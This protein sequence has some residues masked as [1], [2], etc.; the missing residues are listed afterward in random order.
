MK[1][2]TTNFRSVL[3]R[4]LVVAGLRLAL[5][6]LPFGSASPLFAQGNTS[7]PK[8]ILADFNH[9]GIPDLLTPSLQTTGFTISFGAV[10]YGTFSTA[11]ALAPY[12]VGC[13]GTAIPNFA[14]ADFNGDGIPD[15]ALTC[16]NGYTYSLYVMLGKGDG[17]FTSPVFLNGLQNVFVGD[18]NKDGKQDIVVEGGS[19][20]T[21]L[22]FYPGNGD[23]TF[24]N[25]TSTYISR[26]YASGVTVDINADG[27]PDLAFVSGSS[28]SVSLDLYL[29]NQNGTFG[30]IANYSASPN[31][32]ATLTSS[33]IVNA[34]SLLVGNL[35]GTGSNGLAVV[36]TG[37]VPGIFTLSYTVSGST[38]T[39]SSATKVPFAG[40]T[41]AAVGSIVSGYADLL[42][43]NG[44][45]LTVYANDGSGD[46]NPTFAN[47]TLP[48]TASYFGV[49]DANGDGYA[50]VFTANPSATGSALTVA[51]V[52]GSATAVSA[53]LTLPAGTDPLAV[54]WKGNVN[55]TGSTSTGQQI[56]NQVASTVALGS[57]PNPAL[58]GNS[59]T[60]TATVAP[61]GGV[62]IVPTGSVNFFDG[63]KLLGNVPLG[64][65]AVAT[66]STSALAVGTHTISA[67][68]SG[69]G[70][71]SASSNSLSQ[72]INQ[73]TP[74][75]SWTPP[76]A[77]TYGTAL[78]ATQLNATAAGITG[79]ALPGTFVYTP[80]A[81]TVLNAG[82]QTL[83]VTFTPTDTVNYTTAT[84]TVA[85]V[86]NPATPLIA[87][88]P[89]VASIVYG[90]ALGAQQLN[91][92]ATGVGGAP[93]SGNFVYTPAS[94][95]VP[96]AGTQRLSVVFLPGSTNY[97]SATGSASIN[98]TQAT[99]TLSWTTPAAIAYGIPLS[100]TQLNATAAGVSG[101]ALPGT[102]VY[103][104]AAG[105]ILN[106]G[107]QTLSVT[108]T[109]TD[110][111][112]YA[113]ATT[114][115]K[116]TVTDIALTS[117]TP[118]SVGLGAANTTITITGSGFVAT[119]VAQIGG[120]AIAT[121]L[122]NP[123]TLTAIVPAADFA[124]PGTL[125]LTLK[126]PATGSVSGSLPLT[127]TAP[128]VTATLT[129]PA[130][131]SPGSQPVIGL[132]IP[133]YPVAL[134]ATFTLTTTADPKVGV[135]DPNVLF[136]NGLTTY[137]FTIP[138]GST[139]IPTVQLQAGTV[140]ETITVPL[141]LTANGVNVT[142]TNLA[143]AVILVPEAVPVATA[144]TL[145]RSGSTL[146]V[147]I[148][149]F[150][151]TREIVSAAFHFVAASGSTL[152]TTDVPAPVGTVFATYYGGTASQP[153]GSSFVY[154]QVFNVSGDAKAVGSV[155]VTLTNSIGQ[156]V[157]VTAQ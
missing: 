106:P 98:V 54:A 3:A 107:T 25:F 124:L 13:S 75:L 5:V 35:Y 118:N 80:A 117:F 121:T 38:V 146:T 154:T 96:S 127:V 40:L 62:Q 37:A 16:S 79:G 89:A 8:M 9:D 11:S 111:V 50:D 95:T 42:V 26:N 130:S 71:F 103:T 19:D 64:T 86:V 136:S 36:D 152:S 7:S 4:T 97:S 68:Y 134:T 1:R 151:N 45:T 18:F 119:T 46:F 52:S 102:F 83:S 10:P 72:Q 70:I 85:L 66:L 32:S 153:F 133:A 116:Q 41:G 90:T 92:A 22:L 93:L 27:Y 88:T 157:V 126:N 47:L 55:L 23:G 156:S 28:N 147:T 123:T 82:T 142:P 129:A 128:P 76:A 56:V 131:T 63:T 2:A 15:L 101:A 94:G 125:Q 67:A 104:P 30:A 17:T 61:A 145:T 144:A 20:G 91:A 87:W 110:A 74:A 34:S 120:T 112:D 53:P 108:F 48:S 33:G 60:F 31:G 24:G 14:A 115:V 29:N 105:A 155:Q 58:A 44:T 149:G 57:S 114:T 49:A 150:S 77:I 65:G 12:P 81:G 132:T 137:T 148:D 69:D 138:A 59:V 122:V 100:A 99:P 143:P 51:L 84:K 73:N 140:A 109:P 39:P 78:S 6:A 43:S 21:S 141:T 113:S 135:T 139:T